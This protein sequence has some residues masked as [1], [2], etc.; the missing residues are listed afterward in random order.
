MGTSADQA[1]GF[2]Y[3]EGTWVYEKGLPRVRSGLPIDS[4]GPRVLL[5]TDLSEASCEAEAR[6]IEL[7][8]RPGAQLLILA[9]VRPESGRTVVE[10]HR[11]A[12]LLQV[13]R[14]RG[15][16]AKGRLLTDRPAESTLLVAAATGS[17]V[18]VMG[19]HQ[20]AEWPAGAD[21]SGHV[22]LHAHCPVLIA[23]APGAAWPAPSVVHERARAPL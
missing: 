8:A 17:D 19:D 3:P 13:A 2:G 7:A 9:V 5:V 22:I 15:M 12:A 18:I 11:L 14:L 16:R 10:H 6:G 1:T 4:L 21:A 20:W 23:R